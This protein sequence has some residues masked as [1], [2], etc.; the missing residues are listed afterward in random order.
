[1]HFLPLVQILC[2]TT[3]WALLI[4]SALG[5]VNAQEIEEWKEHYRLYEKAVEEENL[6]S[7]VVYARRASLASNRERGTQDRQSGVLAYNLGVVNFELGR[8]GD[9]ADALEQALSSYRTHYG[10]TDLK[11]TTPL[12]KLAA[13]RQ[14][15]K[16][17]V[18]AEK[19]YVQALQILDKNPSAKNDLQAGLILAQL[20]QIAEGLNDPRRTRSYGLR[21]LSQIRKSEHRDSI[22]AANLHVSVARA[23]L[24]LGNIAEA[25]KHTARA[26]VLYEEQLPDGDSRLMGVYGFAAS[27]YEQTGKNSTAR[28]YRRR[29]QQNKQQ[30]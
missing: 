12:V 24:Q 17:W 5:S 7:A 19:Q 4:L 16:Q 28:K 14:A 11:T 29:I 9:A 20:T 30:D 22:A 8:Y 18:P 23:E 26:V 21:G 3:I 13:A 10:A 6:E 2:R 15:L 1:M 25:R 27:V